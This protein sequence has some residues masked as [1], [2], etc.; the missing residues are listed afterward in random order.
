MDVF[1]VDF[2]KFTDAEK[3][4]LLVASVGLVVSSIVLYITILSWKLKIGQS[5]RASLGITTTDKSY[6]SN[7]IVENF[8][9]RDLV[10]FGI[11]LKFGANIYIDLLDIDTHYDRYHPLPYRQEYSS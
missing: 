2:S 4:N 1:G 7:I 8:K 6:V 3:L 5:V 11:Y 9:D 10:I